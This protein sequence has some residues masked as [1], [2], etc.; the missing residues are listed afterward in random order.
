MIKL[1]SFISLILPMTPPFVT[2]SSFIFRFAIRS[3]AAAL[4]FLREYNEEIKD[5]EDEYERKQ[6]HDQAAAITL[7]K[8]EK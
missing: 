3:A 6:S 5:P 7:K 8:Q 4:S 1:V 2:T